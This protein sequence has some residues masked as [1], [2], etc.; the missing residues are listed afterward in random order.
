MKII[1]SGIQ[2]TNMLT[3]GN[4]LGALK[5][6]IE[7]QNENKMFIFIADLHSITVNFEPNKLKENRLSIAAMYYACG[8]NLENNLV[9]Y[10]S[11]VIEHSH[12]A[13]ILLCHSYMGELNRMTQFKDKSS[14]M[15]QAN[16]T[17]NIPTGLLIYPGLMAADILLYDADIVPV[18][19]DQKQHLELTRDLAIRFNKKYKTNIFK[20]PEIFIQKSGAKIM[21]LVDPTIKMSK[22]N[23]NTKGTI[24]LLEPIESIRKKILSAKTDCLNQVKFDIENQPGISNLINIYSSLSNMSV[25]EIE[26]KYQNQNYG[27][28]KNDLADIVCGH[29]EKIQEKY[30]MIINDNSF[31][32]KIIKNGK[33]CKDI[34]S[35]KINDIHKILGLYSNDK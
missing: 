35:K 8:L 10:Q 12:L 30:N 28:F 1:V 7:L 33:I 34:A 16:Q 27:T 15:V 26:N 6:F 5:N 20:I 3:L 11:S 14:K 18:G 9:F 21:D 2:S 19:S 31:E 25:T 29:I 4:Y 32:E 17:V 13:Y 23:Q 22:S 24:F